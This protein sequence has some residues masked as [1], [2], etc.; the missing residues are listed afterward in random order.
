[1]S[2]KRGWL[3]YDLAGNFCEECGRAKFNR[4]WVTAQDCETCWEAITRHRCTRLPSVTDRAPGQDWECDDC[5]SFWTLTVEEEACPDCCSE[6]GHTVTTRRWD[7]TEE[8]DRMDT[9]PRHKPGPLWTPFRNPFPRPRPASLSLPE[10]C[11]RMSSG[12][13]VH[14]KP[15][16]RCP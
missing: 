7:R 8:G 6:C 16:C 12:S 3:P 14:V 9:A 2:D 4:L 10:E 15:G 13:M 11:Y 1:M 5:G